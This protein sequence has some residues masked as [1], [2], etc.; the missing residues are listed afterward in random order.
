LHS[1]HAERPD[2]AAK[3]AKMLERIWDENRALARRYTRP[4]RVPMTSEEIERL[5]SLGY[6]R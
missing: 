5:R 3:Y 1:L 6:I 2:L 4:A